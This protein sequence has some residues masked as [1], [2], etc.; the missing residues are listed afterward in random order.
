MKSEA[1]SKSAHI[2]SAEHAAQPPGRR[3][4][5]AQRSDGLGGIPVSV[6]AP[7]DLPHPLE[8]FGK[9]FRVHISTHFTFNPDT[10]SRA[11][12]DVSLDAG[13]RKWAQESH[14]L[15]RKMAYVA[16]GK[17]TPSETTKRLIAKHFEPAVPGSVMRQA[18]DGYD[19]RLAPRSDW[20]TVLQGLQR[21]QDQAL[22]DLCRCLSACDA[23]ALH[24]RALAFTGR[25]EA[26]RAHVDALFR[27]DTE[28]WV[29]L[30]PS[31][32]PILYVL[33]EVALKAVAWLECRLPQPAAG[34]SQ[35]PSWL[36]GLLEPGS[37]PMGH[38]LSQVC[39]ASGRRNLGQL[40]KKLEWRE[41]YRG[42]AISHDRLRKWASSKTVLMPQAAMW[43]V[44]SAV[45]DA[46]SVEVLHG[47]F[48]AA[49]LFTFLCALLRAGTR[50]ERP[51]WEIVQA[52]LRS[53]YANAY[54][55]QVAQAR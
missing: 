9:S 29:D 13:M 24:V 8:L 52:H 47:Q 31:L 32:V 33:V 40:G 7:I 10:L 37:R 41:K 46:R 43:P 4:R 18:L 1:N 16:A 26:A 38:W 27:A 3:A 11:V 44:L 45:S 42:K 49:R 2:D 19:V 20:D 54:R 50:G 12:M 55:L 6:Y 35:R 48:L 30:H 51:Q 5:P 36:E 14:Q 15:L 23:H 39:E 17:H 22:K 53:Q 25:P 21:S 28:A 34:P